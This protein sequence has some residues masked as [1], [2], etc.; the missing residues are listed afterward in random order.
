[1]VALGCTLFA[2]SVGAQSRGMT[3]YQERQLSE[4]FERDARQMMKNAKAQQDVADGFLDAMV[5]EMS[6][7]ERKQYLK[8]K[9]EKQKARKK[10]RDMALGLDQRPRARRDDSPVTLEVKKEKMR[11]ALRVHLVRMARLERL[12]EIGKTRVNSTLEKRTKE[13]IK[14]ERRRRAGENMWLESLEVIP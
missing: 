3:K 1:M 7:S 13:L 14:M 4:R 9:A 2:W 8:I 6:P 11:L 12:E 5:D 10:K